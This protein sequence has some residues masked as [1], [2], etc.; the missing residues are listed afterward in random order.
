MFFFIVWNFAQYANKEK[1]YY[2]VIYSFFVWKKSSN[3]EKN[4]FSETFCHIWI[5]LLACRNF[6]E[7]LKTNYIGFKNLL[8]FNVKS[9]LGC[10]PMMQ[11]L[12]FEKNSLI[13]KMLISI[14]FGS[15]FQKE[16][17]VFVL[18]L[19]NSWLNFWSN[20]DTSSN[21]IYK[22]SSLVISPKT[23]KLIQF[24]TRFSFIF[25]PHK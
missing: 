23:F 19:K 21:W 22:A 12:K 13:E 1:K 9:F 11:Y 7:I 25:I 18:I 10:Y 5:F 24:K 3:F 8:P 15:W 14:S 6:K 4:Y 16:P 2:I 20:L 17:L